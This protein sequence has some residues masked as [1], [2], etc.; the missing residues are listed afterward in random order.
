[1]TENQ[2]VTGSELQLNENDVI[3][4]TTGLDGD[5]THINEDFYRITGY[6]EEELL[7]KNQ[8]AICHSDMPK[9]VLKDLWDTAQSGK[10]W[11]GPIKI[12]TKSDDFFWVDAYV[13]PIKQDG[14]IVEYQSV[15]TKL[16]K[17]TAERANA[18]YKT[19]RNGET[20][21]ALIKPV[22]SLRN[23]LFLS[24]CVA[25]LP[26]IITSLFEIASFYS[27][28]ATIAGLGIAW[29]LTGWLTKPL[30]RTRG[31]AA[32][33]VGNKKYKLTKYIYSGNT[34]EFGTIELALK[35]GRSE[36]RAIVSRV[37]DSADVLFNDAMHLVS[38]SEKSTKEISNLN[39]QTNMIAVAINELSATSKE[40]AK[41]AETATE[42]TSQV[43]EET[44]SSRE[45]VNSTVNSINNLS[46]EVENAAG[47]IENLEKDSRLVSNVLDV[48][49]DIAEQTN[50]L[51]LNA[52]IEAARAGEHGRGFA[53]VADEVRKLATETQ[54]STGEI[55][56]IIEN[57]QSM[58][59]NAVEV[60]QTG[61]KEAEQSVELAGKAYSSLDT[62]D[63]SIQIAADV[64][65]QISVAAREQSTVVEEININITSI[66]DHADETLAVAKASES[67]SGV[68]SQQAMQ[69]SKLAKHFKEIK[70]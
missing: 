42:S 32:S 51:A 33:M 54:N 60:M 64:V 58:A 16:D 5:I 36:N 27:I 70:L 11:I 48:I 4:S 49:R 9:L 30:Y 22:I 40:V 7:G 12:R 59:R 68:V 29:G 69:M 65:H 15:F 34:D 13:T 24:F 47:V 53:V 62:I 8:N 26:L 46:K 25:L 31:L 63:G 52:A 10:S 6:S 28:L 57:L 41:N 38:N 67:S 44:R 19:L 50:L 61:K 35:V 37:Q 2:K 18:A 14:K 66:K 55:S 3:L 23:R 39:G 43:R 45:I 20:L 17:N 1:M 21:A 56:Q